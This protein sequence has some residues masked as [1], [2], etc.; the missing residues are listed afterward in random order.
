[1][2]TQNLELATTI[3]ASCMLFSPVFYLISVTSC[4][5]CGC[6]TLKAKS[7][8]CLLTDKSDGSRK[9]LSLF[10][11]C[12]QTN[13]KVISLIWYVDFKWKSVWQGLRIE[14]IVLQLCPRLPSSWYCC[15]WAQEIRTNYSYYAQTLSFLILYKL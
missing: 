5:F 4:D 12:L 10:L 2:A 9:V 14:M 6:L 3:K 7:N 11:T 15:I 1:M 13:Y 8:S